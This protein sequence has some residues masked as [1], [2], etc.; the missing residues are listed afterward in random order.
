[1]EYPSI[2][3][4]HETKK[5]FPSLNEL[6]RW[7]ANT[8][9]DEQ[10]HERIKEQVI[11]TSLLWAA[12]YSG[13]MEKFKSRTP[14]IKFMSRRAVEQIDRGDDS[15]LVHEHIIPKKMLSQA[16]WETFRRDHAQKNQCIEEEILRLLRLSV[17]CLVTKEEDQ[18]L[19]KNGF[20]Q[21][22]PGPAPLKEIVDGKVSLGHIWCRYSE[23]R[24]LDKNTPAP[25][26]VL[27][28]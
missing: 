1:M 3:G 21:T 2:E 14:S 27:R 16:I 18:I 22:G 6:S 23:C 19:S 17:Y 28:V 24:D 11:I 26:E 9:R 5:G 7:I 20:R 15:G 13:K 25:I 10:I 8:L 12:D 4:V